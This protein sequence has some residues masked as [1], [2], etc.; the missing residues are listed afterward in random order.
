VP[1]ISR[2]EAAAE[3]LRR[4]E[5]RNNLIK[6]CQFVM[7]EYQPAKHHRYIADRLMDVFDGKI[8]RLIVEAPCGHG[9]SQLVSRL[10]PAFWIGKRPTDHIISSTYN[11]DFAG[12]FGRDVRNIL[13][14]DT[15]QSLF[16]DTFLSADSRAANRWSTNRG[17]RYYSVGVEG[18]VTGRRG[19]LIL[20]DDPLKGRSDADSRSVRND[21]WKWYQSELYTR[22]FPDTAICIISTRWHF[23]DLVGR[24]L[25]EEEKGG[26]KWVRVTLPA[27]A[28]SDDILGRKPGEPLWPEW[29]TLKLLEQFRMTTGPREWSALYQQKPVADEGAYFQESWLID[30]DLPTFL[31]THGVKGGKSKTLRFYGASD[32][33]E[34]MEI[35]PSI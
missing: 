31:A 27:I 1:Q 24:L 32:Y 7:P 35:I 6:F 18:G 19:H 11:S 33:G 26:E 10:F 5:A 8:R 15:Y 29:Y 20:I 2:E 4:N 23:D 25:I 22:Q 34:M 17:G 30:Y 16:P 3:L 14:L 12:D 21:L 28:E 9:K 13:N